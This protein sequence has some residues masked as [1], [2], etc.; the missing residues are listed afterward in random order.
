MN[1]LVLIPLAGLAACASTPSSLPSGPEAY[2]T[3]PAASPER[4]A[5]TYRIGAQ[6]KVNIT[7]FQEPELSL[8]DVQVDAAGEILLPLIGSVRAQGRTTRE[9]S[10][11]IA[12][13]LDRRY[14]VDPQVSVIVSSSVSQKVTVEGS[15]T[16]PGVYEVRGETTLLEA[17]AMAKGPSRVAALD[18]V[19]VFRTI[20]GQRM[21]ALFDI[22]AIRRGEAA[23]PEIRGND[24]IVVGLSNV[25]AVWRDALAA[26][27]ALAIFRPLAN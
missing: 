24:T 1:R 5:E 15:V 9:L 23:D 14:L 12:D 7:V 26:V 4:A 10:T 2:A 27:P 11:E 17:L 8:Q 6:D 20:G 3:I 13:K 18:Q 25:K 21:G 16:E 19:A 22:R